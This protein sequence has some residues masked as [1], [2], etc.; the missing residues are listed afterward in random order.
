MNDVT[1]IDDIGNHLVTLSQREARE[2]MET[3]SADDLRSILHSW[4]LAGFN[5][6]ATAEAASRYFRSVETEGAES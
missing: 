3:L 5:A 1:N 2:Y 4:D 6:A